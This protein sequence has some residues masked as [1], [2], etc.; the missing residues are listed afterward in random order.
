MFWVKEVPP[1]GGFV[2]PYYDSMVYVAGGLCL[3]SVA[4]L[5]LSADVL[6]C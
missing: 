1:D 3:G 2:L 5:G 4:S 6:L